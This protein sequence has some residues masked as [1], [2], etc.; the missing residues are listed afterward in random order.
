SGPGGNLSIGSTDAEYTHRLR[1]VL[2]RPFAQ[3]FE[4]HFELVAHRITD[5][6]RHENRSRIGNAFKPCRDVD[7]VAID[8]AIFDD[9]IA[10]VDADAEFDAALLGFGAIALGH[11]GLDSGR[12]AYSF[13]PAGKIAQHS[14][15]G[16]LDDAAPVSGDLGPNT[17]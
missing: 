8:V 16:P 11:A 12:A 13:D 9:D 10:Q 1:D 3:I 5:G 7:A 2:H 17:F 4:S 14:V 6:A 15:A